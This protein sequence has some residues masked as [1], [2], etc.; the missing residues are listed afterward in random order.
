MI[1]IL[2][3]PPHSNW[4]KGRIEQEIVAAHNLLDRMG[5]PRKHGDRE[6]TL[7]GRISEI[8][9]RVATRYYE[10]RRS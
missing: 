7:A 3:F 2:S 5:A 4:D 1:D 10:R 9:F 8:N 6:L